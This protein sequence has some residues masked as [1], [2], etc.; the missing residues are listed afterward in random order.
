M[1]PLVSAIMPVRGR[2]EWAKKAMECFQAQTYQNKELVILGDADAPT[3]DQI[4]LPSNVNH[5]V[6]LERWQIGRKRNEL[7]RDAKGEIICHW[8][9]DDWSHPERIEAQVKLLHESG[10]V[11]L[12]FH[13]MYFYRVEDQRVCLYRGVNV[14]GI[15]TSFMYTREF[16]AKHPFPDKQS[17]E[18]GVFRKQAAAVNQLSCVDGRSMMVARVHADNTSPKPMRGSPWIPAQISDMPKEFRIVEG[19]E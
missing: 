1:N 7:C 18:D 3:F 4:R 11:M 8:D 13:S 10:R 6:A 12:A 5:I 15:G 17:G 9:S 16:W 19:L 2:R 14:G